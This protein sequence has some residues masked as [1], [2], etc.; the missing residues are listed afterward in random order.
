M[1][2]EDI[3]LED[4]RQLLDRLIADGWRVVTPFNPLAAASSGGANYT[5]QMGAQLLQFEWD[6]R[7]DWKV[8]GRDDVVEQ[9]LDKYLPVEHPL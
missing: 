6:Q 3:Q 4:G 5:V 9:V 2:V 1:I 7:F 8:S